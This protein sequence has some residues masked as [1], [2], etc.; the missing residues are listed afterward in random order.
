MRKF[1]ESSLNWYF[2]DVH[3][4][5]VGNFTKAHFTLGHIFVYSLYLSFDLQFK[6]FNSGNKVC[7]KTVHLI[8]MHTTVWQTF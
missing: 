6:D 2:K 4:Y 1:L 7:W 8:Q 3:K 5:K